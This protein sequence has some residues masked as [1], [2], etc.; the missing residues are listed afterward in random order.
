MPLS[1]Q[2]VIIAGLLSWAALYCAGVCVIVSTPCTCNEVEESHPTCW[3]HTIGWC[4]SFTFTH[5]KIIKPLEC[6]ISKRTAEPQPTSYNCSALHYCTARIS[7]TDRQ[8]DPLCLRLTSSC[9][10][11]S[12]SPLIRFV[13]GALWNESH[14]EDLQYCNVMF[15]IS[16][17]TPLEM[18][19]LFRLMVTFGCRNAPGGIFIQVAR[20]W[21]WT[22]AVSTSLQTQ[23]WRQWRGK[24]YPCGEEQKA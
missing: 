2:K 15:C 24:Y 5:G 7:V 19:E 20:M 3:Q 18:M 22:P 17:K 23:W 9:S 10:K 14:T 12:A 6:L 8:A 21:V 13:W 16:T 11:G 4:V 1:Y